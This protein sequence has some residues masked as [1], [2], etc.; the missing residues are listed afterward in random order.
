[1]STA[2]HPQRLEAPDLPGVARRVDH[3]VFI[4]NR[5]RNH[6]VLSAVLV[7]LVAAALGAEIYFRA[8]ARVRLHV[9]EV[10]HLGNVR[11]IGPAREIDASDPRIVRVQLVEWIRQARTVTSDQRL[12]QLFVRTATDRTRGQARTALNELLETRN[13][14]LTARRAA[15]EV[16]EIT[17]LPIP[18]TPHWEV[19]WTERRRRARTA[20]PERTERWRAIVRFDWQAPQDAEGETNPLGFIL[21]HVEWTRLGSTDASL[22]DR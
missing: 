16:T 20:V 13:P 5:L 9:V 11:A 1:M 12:Q 17:A 3:Y 7:V 4:R 6:Q 19:Q 21:T 2:D 18:D 10:D 8:T 14:F 22:G 15:I